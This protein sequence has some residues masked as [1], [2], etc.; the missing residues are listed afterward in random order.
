MDILGAL[1]PCRAGLPGTLGKALRPT[2]PVRAGRWPRSGLVHGAEA[3]R[4]P[5]P[6]GQRPAAGPSRGEAGLREGQAQGAG[7]GAGPAHRREEPPRGNV[8]VQLGPRPL[9]RLR[10]SPRWSRAPSLACGCRRP[11]PPTTLRAGPSLGC[12]ASAG[13][14]GDRAP[15]RRPG[16]VALAPAQGWSRLKGFGR[17]I[18]RDSEEGLLFAL[19]LRKTITTGLAN[20]GAGPDAVCICQWPRAGLWQAPSGKGPSWPVLAPPASARRMEQA[21]DPQAPPA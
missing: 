8:A 21:W 3:P 20:R 9:G 2:H 17:H 19:W 10:P 7:A 6:P 13:R 5:P 4:G 16:P 15:R 12:G 11:S 1:L 14:T 18:L